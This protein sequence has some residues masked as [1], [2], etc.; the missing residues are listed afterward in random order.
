MSEQSMAD[1]FILVLPGVIGIRQTCGTA[2]T[3]KLIDP[4]ISF[5]SLVEIGMFISAFLDVASVE[6]AL[7]SLQRNMGKSEVIDPG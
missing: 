2:T 3:E 6:S 4:R 5:R 7:L 1:Y